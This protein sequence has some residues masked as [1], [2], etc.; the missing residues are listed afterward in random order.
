MR[1]ILVVDDDDSVIRLLTLFFDDL[2]YEV[3]A[4]HDGMGA[5]E[6][7]M[8]YM[9]DV[10]ILDIMIPRLTG[11]RTCQFIHQQKGFEKL[12]IIFL[13]AK[14]HPSDQ[15]YGYVVGCSAYLTKPIDF[16]L[17]SEKVERLT[18]IPY[19]DLSERPEI[20]REDPKIRWVD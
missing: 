11:F 5:V 9:P 18:N 4:A 7:A 12:P 16:D 19:A 2:G 3:V 17:L 15:K 13:T 10:M 14:D 20:D 8:K 1:R 6:L